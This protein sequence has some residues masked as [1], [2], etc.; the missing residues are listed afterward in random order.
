[1]TQPYSTGIAF[2]LTT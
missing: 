1:V 2:P